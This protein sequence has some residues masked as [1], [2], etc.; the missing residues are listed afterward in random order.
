MITIDKN[1][2][3]ILRPFAEADAAALYKLVDDNRQHLRQWL[4][5]V[6]TTT[7]VDSAHSFIQHS[8]A[9]IRAQ[10]S[11]ALG[12]FYHQQLIGGIGMHNWNHE[13]KSAEIG[14][15]LAAP[16]Q[17]KGLLTQ[18]ASGLIE[19]LFHQLQLNRIE[20]RFH[21]NNKKSAAV[22]ERLHFKV[23][24]LLRDAHLCNGILHDMVVAG[25]LHREWRA[26]QR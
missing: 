10:K 6:D 7:S 5:W 2:E 17:G 1:S 15:W 24:G 25:L 26:I 22:A 8:L 3:L 12:I 23:E 16:W 21:P 4:S 18:S 9:D 13:V 11:L 14:Y 20:L 19:Y